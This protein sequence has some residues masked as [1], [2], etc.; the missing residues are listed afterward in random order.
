MWA[1]GQRT[2]SSDV[3]TSAI[4][5]FM[6]KLASPIVCLL[7]LSVFW[8]SAQTTPNASRPDSSSPQPQ[9]IK[10][11]SK[12]ALILHQKTSV[13]LRLPTHVSGLDDLYAIVKSADEAGYVV[14]LGSTPNCGGQHVC[15]YGT[16]IGTTRSLNQIDEYAISGRRRTSV[17]L[18][19]GLE[20]Y[21][22]ESVCGPIA[23]I[24]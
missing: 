7:V 12:A 17:E 15:S 11:F 16:L 10:A 9:V 19:H 1:P 2:L 8:C 18:Q 24:R 21:F 6:V 5:S 20:G 13:P 14:V 3:F 4:L 22:Y 23:A